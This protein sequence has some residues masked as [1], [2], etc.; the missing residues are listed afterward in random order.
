MIL[1]F[2]EYCERVKK[3]PFLKYRQLM[4]L[5]STKCDCDVKTVVECYQ[6]LVC[7]LVRNWLENVR[8]CGVSPM[9]LVQAG[10]IG[11]QKAIEAF[12]CRRGQCFY[13]IAVRYIQIQIKREFY[14]HTVHSRDEGEKLIAQYEKNRKKNM[15]LCKETEP[16]NLYPVTYLSQV[17]GEDKEGN[18]LKFEDVLPDDEMSRW[19]IK[20]KVD[21]ILKVLKKANGKIH[22]LSE[23]IIELRHGVGSRRYCEPL[24]LSET[25]KIVHYS[26]V[27]VLNIENKVLEFLRKQI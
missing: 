4:E 21:D 23:K 5:L 26:K 17:I 12:D 19:L 27:G 9:D 14:K 3:Y 8:R 13:S 25:G 1:D 11:L 10:S 16:L 6:R 22:P 18:P 24:S 20:L 2:F 7:S 15:L